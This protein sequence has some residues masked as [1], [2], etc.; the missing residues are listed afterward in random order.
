LVASDGKGNDGFGRA[1]AISGDTLIVGA[2]VASVP[3]PQSIVSNIGINGL[4][5]VNEQGFAYAFSGVASDSTTQ[6]TISGKV[7][8]TS[9]GSP[10]GGVV[11]RLSGQRTA[12]TITDAAGNY[13]FLNVDT[14]ASYVVTPSRVNYHFTPT[15]LSLSLT[16]DKTDANFA[17]DLDLV[18]SGNPS[19]TPEFFVRQHYLDFLSREPDDTGFN[20]WT[21]EITSC[22]VN[23]QCIE[24]KRINVS[25]AFF[26][27]IE[28]QQTGYLVYRIYKTAY[29]NLPNAP[30]PIHFAEFL[31]DDQQIGQGLVVN[32]P[33]WEQLLETNKQNFLNGFVLRSRFTNLYAGVSDAA[34]VAM[35]ISNAEG[36]L[37][38]NEQQVLVD[39]LTAGRKTRAQVL[40]VVAESSVLSQREF[41]RAFVLMQY[42]GYLRRDPNSGP[43]IDFSGYNFWLTKLNQFNGDFIQAEMVKA[44]LTSTEYRQRFSP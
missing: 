12:T 16:G 18:V 34:F 27:S 42:F 14:N 37:S 39:D 24:V 33:G 21:N 20:F 38:A 43:D 35:L 2:N 11:I 31:A 10:L 4:Q 32:S 40:R 7:T 6:A 44:F 23:A 9:D 29:G 1:V 13:R 28:F 8:K 19:D 5:G 25:A 3:P 22:G 26:L 36:V 15:S 30:V 17:G 41:N